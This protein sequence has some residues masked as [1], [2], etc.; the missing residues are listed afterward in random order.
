MFKYTVIG[1]AVL[2]LAG[3]GEKS[4]I[5]DAINKSIGEE[6]YCYSLQNND[7][8]FPIEV[9]SHPLSRDVS[10][11]LTG[12]VNQGLITLQ[13]SGYNSY[14]INLTEKGARTDF[15][16]KNKGVCVGK[17]EVDEIKEWVEGDSQAIQVTYTEELTDVPSWVDKKQFS[18]VGG[19][20]KPIEKQ[21]VLQKTNNGYR[22]FKF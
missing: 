3:C 22:A 7:I 2:V 11:I 6:E 14:T 9:R 21:I 8:Y 17:R 12:L 1:L 18:E 20:N 15:W 16:D 13:K 5:K 19:M 4:D 10:P